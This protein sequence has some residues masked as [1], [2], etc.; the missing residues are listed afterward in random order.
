[1]IKSF[2]HILLFCQSLSLAGQSATDTLRLLFAGDIMGHGPQIRSAELEKDQ[3]YDYHESF[4]FIQPFLQQADLAIGNLEL[5]LPGEPPYLGFPMFRSPDALAEALREAG[6]DI[7]LTANNHAN[8]GGREG[9]IRTIGTLHENGFYQTGT[10]K[11]ANDKAL[12]Y[13]LIVYKKGFKL[14]FLNYTYSTN[15][16]KTKPPTIVNDLKLSSIQKD[17]EIARQLHA[18]VIIVLLHW[19]KEYEEQQSAEQ[20][21]IA[22]QLFQ[23]GAD[24]IIGSHPHVVQPI[25][26]YAV[27]SN[28]ETRYGLVAYS[29]GNFISNQRK[30]LT[31]GGILLEVCLVNKEGQ[32]QL[33]EVVYHP[34][35]RY[36]HRL[37]KGKPVFYC[38]PIA[39]F[40]HAENSEL[41][42]PES[43]LQQLRTYGAYIRKHLIT[44]DCV[45][46]KSN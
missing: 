10:F 40:E 35:W 9:L 38:L 37:K 30:A 25:R 29:L 36:V 27:G 15:R 20:E 28:K 24:L 26:K 16:N 44:S 43:A 18:D 4:R 1:M 23:W 42:I 2:F 46:W 33:D 39:A 14:A 22:K 8:D 12:L 19:G 32:A 11:N 7:L 3:H 21:R 5:T 13:P 41:T 45:E 31:D 34:V 17:L 6:F